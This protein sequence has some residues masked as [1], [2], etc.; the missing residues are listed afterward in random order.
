MMKKT[1]DI[2]DIDQLMND[3]FG[4]VGS[5]ERNEFRKEAYNYCVGQMIFEA[6]KKEKMTQSILAEKVGTTKSYIS[7][8]EN[9]SIDPGASMFLRM[10]NALGL[11]L[12][13][14]KPIN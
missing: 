5:S 11:R 2:I 4:Q 3:K 12:D 6:R 14:V 8:V 9:G 13:L 10:I 1:N 7:R